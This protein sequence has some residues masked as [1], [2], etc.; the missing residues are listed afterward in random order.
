LRTRGGIDWEGERKHERL[1]IKDQQT[2][3]KKVRKAL[4]IQVQD[5]SQQLMKH[6]KNAC[7]SLNVN[8][9]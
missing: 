5:I 9:K 4:K 1:E 6:D 2:M 3:M 7:D 8:E